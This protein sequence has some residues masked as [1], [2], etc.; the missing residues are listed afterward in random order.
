MNVM[1]LAAGEGTRLRPYTLEK[2]KPA[3]PFFSVPLACYSL[4]LL[5]TLKI[6]KL[7]VN[8][9]HL[10]Q[11][12]ELLFKKITPQWKS[13]HFSPEVGQLL[14]S[15]GGIHN[16]K[17]FLQGG[18]DFFVVNADEVILPHEVKIL[19]DMMAFHKRHKGI[20]T[21]MTMDHPEVGEK[22]GGAWLNEGTQVQ[23]FSKK[24]PGPHAPRGQ[25]FVGVMIL[26]DKIFSYFK[27]QIVEENILYETL[28]AAM[29]AGEDVHAF[30][31]QAEWF[32]TGNPVDFMK[33]TEA[34]LNAL[35]NERSQRPF[36]HEHLRQTVC[37]Y[38]QDQYMI[39]NDWE[40][41]PELKELVR[42]I[43]EGL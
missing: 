14:G 40:R 28:T 36:W 31:V 7:V 32:E 20:A 33:A 16:A 37:L 39:E 2:P 43:K 41:L 23:C 29:A 9:Y 3:I 13:L 15:G 18:G 24:A 22:F 1:M 11:N 34:C 35:Q 5:D 6:D 17:K 25:H 30:Q 27:P 21:L 4:S 42:K 12:I 10:P 19:N 38:S 8:T 26:S